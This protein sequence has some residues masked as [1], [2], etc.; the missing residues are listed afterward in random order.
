MEKV[1]LIF[2]STILIFSCVPQK[3]AP[4]LIELENICPSF[5]DL[6]EGC[7]TVKIYHCDTLRN[8]LSSYFFKINATDISENSQKIQLCYDYLLAIDDEVKFTTGNNGCGGLFRYLDALKSSL[9][10]VEISDNNKVKLLFEKAS[11][12]E[13]ENA[14]NTNE[15]LLLSTLFGCNSDYFHKAYQREDAGDAR[16]VLFCLIGSSITPESKKAFL[17]SVEN[18]KNSDV[19]RPLIDSLLEEYDRISQKE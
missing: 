19:F 15:V 1:I 18:H 14:P 10:Y 3:S 17:E 5:P 4:E 7:T 13:S 2:L 11:K 16:I 9:D 8:C 12:K 6:I